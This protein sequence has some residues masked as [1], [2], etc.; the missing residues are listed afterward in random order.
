FHSHWSRMRMARAARRAGTGRPEAKNEMSSGP[1]RSALQRKLQGT[2]RATA[3]ER[4]ETKSHA[5]LPEIGVAGDRVIATQPVGGKH[6][7]SGCRRWRRPTS[8]PSRDVE[9]GGDHGHIDRTRQNEMG[10]PVRRTFQPGLQPPVKLA[11][12]LNPR[13]RRALAGTHTA[14]PNSRP[15]VR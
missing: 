11:R 13:I 10:K 1:A 4:I 8:E 5:D 2:N 6:P 15:Y 12:P 9:D 7:S 14:T 3:A